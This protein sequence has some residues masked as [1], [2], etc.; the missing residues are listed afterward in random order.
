MRPGQ[1]RRSLMAAACTL[2][3]CLNGAPA[4]AY[5]HKPV[6]PKADQADEPRLVMLCMA[7]LLTGDTAIAESSCGKALELDPHDV[8]AYKLRGYAYLVDHRFEMAESDFR[9]GVKLMPNDHE[10]LAGLGQSLAGQGRFHDSVRYFSRAVAL[11][12]EHAAYWSARC[13]ARGGEGVALRAA[14]SDCDKA[15]KLSP[16]APVALN[17]RG[18]V[19]LKLHAY[20]GAVADYDASLAA[21]ESQP[22]ARFGRGLAH[23]WLAD[24]KAGVADILEARRQDPGIDD[25]FVML[26]VIPAQCG[27]HGDTC[28]PNY[29]A[30][31]VT[32]PPVQGT[33]VVSQQ[34]PDEVF[35]G[36]EIGRLELM[37]SQIAN[38]AGEPAR[39]HHP[40]ELPVGEAESL[41]RIKAA[42]ERFNGLLPVACRRAKL[43]GDICA[44]YQPLT[45]SN[46]PG[47]AVGAADDLFL[48]IYPVWSTLCRG[49][50]ARCQLE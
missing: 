5:P 12:P 38:L 49:H 13:W 43:A 46:A 39:G 41:A 3:V 28:P 2:A 36:L 24:A 37:V 10:L 17:S 42:T 44:P 48:H 26:G 45:A 29:P 25:M 18:M 22:S 8:S 9:N 1:F 34:E 23:L 32:P 11:A 50:K 15:L 27:A 47:T 33:M 6:P 35:L 14:L 40:D 21:R 20:A 19:K 4:R 7:A 31:P 30:R 16:A